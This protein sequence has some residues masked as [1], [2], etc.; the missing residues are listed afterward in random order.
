MGI[1][2]TVIVGLCLSFACCIGG[3]VVGE[4]RHVGELAAERLHYQQAQHQ[5]RLDLRAE[6]AYE[7]FKMD[8]IVRD[9]IRKR[10]SEHQKHMK[11]AVEQYVKWLVRCS[12]SNGTMK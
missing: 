1:K 11:A 6:L 4:T 7:Q 12:Q 5:D 2:E 9:T 10:D 8:E 3:Y